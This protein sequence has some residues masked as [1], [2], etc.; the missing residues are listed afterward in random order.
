MDPQNRNQRLQSEKFYRTFAVAT[1]EID[2]EKRLVPL[3]FSS[4]EPLLRWYGYEIL[5]HAPGSVRLGRLTDGAAV[6]VE[7]DPE[8]HVGVVESAQIEADKKG[9]AVARFGKS[10]RAE[11][12]FQDVV[13]GIRTKISVGYMVH[14]SIDKPDSKDEEGNPCY[15]I[16]DWEPFE[17]SFVAIPADATVG[18]GRTMTIPMETTNGTLTISTTTAGTFTNIEMHAEE[19]KANRS[20][21]DGDGQKPNNKHTEVTMNEEKITSPEETLRIER[22][23][24]AE[25]D[26]V[27]AR[28]T[29]RI[30]NLNELRAQAIKGGATAGE[31]KGAI[32]DALPTGTPLEPSSI[33]ADLEKKDIRKY[34]I[35]RAILSQVPGSGVDATLEREASDAIAKKIGKAARGIYIPH[36][37]QKRAVLVQGTGSLGGNIV[38]TE[39]DSANFIEILRNKM[40]AIKLGVKVLPGLV[41]NLA[42]PKLA[43]S[44][45][46]YWVTED[47]ALTGSNPTFGQLTMAP[48]TV[49]G[50]VDIA[51]TLI[52]QSTPAVDGI[53]TDDLTT[54]LALAIDKAILQGSGSAGQPQGIINTPSLAS[55]SN[56]TFTWLMAIAHESTV[57]AANADLARCAFVTTPASLGVLKGKPQ[58]SGYPT[59]MVDKGT[60]NGYSI[61]STG[62]M[63]TANLLFGDFG[64]TLLG[65][66][67][68]PDLLV[69]PYK[70][71][72][73]GTIRVIAFQSVDVGVRQI[74]A[75][76]LGTSVSA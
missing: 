67:G 63:P 40:L 45:T 33:E 54:V 4:E 62:Q 10:E 46:A 71:S 28:F 42:I 30:P 47:A 43:G 17:V 58:Q 19:L 35:A 41:G 21:A 56:G 53:V 66:W 31:F 6:L 3:A 29:G 26:A 75:Y 38:A 65:Q 25:I 12:I 18:V 70:N 13:D 20:S 48:K 51:R 24:V 76:S 60:L 27:T 72:D 44:A 59:Y 2:V 73:K 8:D 68:T 23:R 14:S 1:R 11:E 34:S 55:T 61:W 52:L 64:Q 9:R 15:R 57:D 36:E 16:K 49:G 50:Y 22:E 69:D 32:A 74:G 5:D 7:H 37:I 39:L